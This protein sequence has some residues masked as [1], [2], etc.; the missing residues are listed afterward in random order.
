MG[1]SKAVQTLQVLGRSCSSWLFGKRASGTRSQK[2]TPYR[3][4]LEPLEGRWV[5]SVLG[6]SLAARPSS[7]APLAATVARSKH[8][9]KP[10]AQILSPQDG[11][12]VAR[13][14]SLKG[15]VNQKNGWP[16]V[17]V[18]LLVLDQPFYVQPAVTKVTRGVFKTQAFIG[19]AAT[20]PGTQF[21]IV[22]V[23]APSRAAAAMRFVRG[24]TL[25]T[26]PADLPASPSITVR[27]G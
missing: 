1:R 4:T 26:L 25:P 5:L 12:T 20:K 18:L 10:A 21:R 22:V 16:V 14:V 23:V 17:L 27:R 9:T 13:L 7:P 2:P 3:P 15:Q 19:A 11:A 24:M 6:S 8:K